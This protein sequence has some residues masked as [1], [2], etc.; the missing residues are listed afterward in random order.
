[1]FMG[2]EKAFDRVRWTM[3]MN[4]FLRIGVDWIDIRLQAELHLQ[5][6]MMVRIDDTTLEPCM[7][8]R[9]VRRGYLLPHLLLST[10]QN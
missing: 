2:F 8:G 7:I 9:G 3:M 1:M 6:E 4:T 10:M 5:Q